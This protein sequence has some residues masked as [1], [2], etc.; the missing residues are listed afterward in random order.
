MHIPNIV[1][2][3]VT[4]FKK[5]RPR[6]TLACS[7]N[8]PPFLYSEGQIFPTA[9]TV[10]ADGFRGGSQPDV[11]LVC[12]SP[13][14]VSAWAGS[15]ERCVSVCVY[16]GGGGDSMA[17]NLLAPSH[18]LCLRYGRTSISFLHDLDINYSSITKVKIMLNTMEVL[19]PSYACI[20]T[21][22]PAPLC[23][24]ISLIIYSH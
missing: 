18:Y 9:A 13:E 22:F 17:V 5:Q 3:K 20:F 4:E 14:S 6:Y 1:T 15:N 21:R 23:S 16:V 12:V 11:L 7:N 8:T 19:D 2:N 10:S 24:I